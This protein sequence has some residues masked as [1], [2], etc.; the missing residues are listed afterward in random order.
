MCIGI[1]MRVVSTR[2]FLATCEG[3]GRREEINVLLIGEVQPGQWLLTSLGT[4]REVLDEEQAARLNDALD[5]LEAMQ[6]GETDFDAHFADL[7]GREPVLPPGLA[8]AKE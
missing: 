1:P 2:G 4:A 5:A 3:R 8:C 6:R 7:V